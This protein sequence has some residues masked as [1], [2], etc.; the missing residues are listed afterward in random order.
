MIL[1]KMAPTWTDNLPDW[2]QPSIAAVIAL[3]A[4]VISG[5]DPT[6]DVTVLVDALV[7]MLTSLGIVK[8]RDVVKETKKGN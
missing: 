4:T 3:V 1:R 5:G 8:T 7:A 2:V 6:Q